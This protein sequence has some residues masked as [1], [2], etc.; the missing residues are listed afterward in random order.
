MQDTLKDNQISPAAIAAIGLLLLAVVGLV[1]AARLSGTKPVN[2]PAS[3]AVEVRPIH[4]Q[5]KPDG[6]IGI[7][8][9]GATV[10]FE[11]IQPQTNGFLRGIL[12][13][14]A[15]A[16]KL[17][18]AGQEPPFELARFADGRLSLRDPVDGR[19]IALE[20]FGPSNTA[21]FKRLLTLPGIAP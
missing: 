8:D 7:Y 21:V 20:P 19:E 1:A 15:R 18:H 13:G 5:D 4:F 11:V 9:S 14:M 6:S 16:R 3:V 17:N 12:R 2:I 10:P